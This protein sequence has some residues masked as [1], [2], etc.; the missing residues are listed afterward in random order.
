MKLRQVSDSRDT[1]KPKQ[2]PLVRKHIPFHSSFC[3]IVT[4]PWMKLL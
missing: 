2:K 4:T 1:N 3:L